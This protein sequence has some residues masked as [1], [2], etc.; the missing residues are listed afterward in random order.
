MDNKDLKK[1]KWLESILASVDGIKKAEPNPYLFTKIKNRLNE[2]GNS[3]G[4]IP[5]RKAALGFLTIIVLAILNIA[6]LHDHTSNENNTRNELNVSSTEEIIPSQNNPY[7]E[8]LY[9]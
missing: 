5:V 3:M 1:E 8:I 2:K 7:L 4:Y 9:K 6:V